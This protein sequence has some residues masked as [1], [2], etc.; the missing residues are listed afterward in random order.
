MK[1]KIGSLFATLLLAGSVGVQA[2][3]P[4]KTASA[5]PSPEFERMKGLVG[6]WKGKTDMGQGPIEM[7]VE[8]RLI[9]AGSVLEERVFSGTPNEMVTMYFDRG[10]KLAL[11]HYCMLG[12][13]PAMLLKSSDAKTLTFDFDATCGID[14][15]K[16]SHMH[17][18]TI[19]F[20]DA[21]T[22]TTSCKAY[23]DGK[24]TEDHAV[25]LK[26]VKS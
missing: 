21:D 24:E 14:T 11:T 1:T 26:R 2:G 5:S 23:M 20:D 3:G 8:Y 13:R 17:A 16:E 22:I 19:T 15:T 12:N 18:L 9:A 6:A 25:T 7:T 10:G 4:A